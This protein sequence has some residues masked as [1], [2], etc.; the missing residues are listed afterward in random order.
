MLIVVEV[1]GPVTA[2]VESEELCDAAVADE[3]VVAADLIAAGAKVFPHGRI[4]VLGADVVS[5]AWWTCRSLDR[6]IGSFDLV[7][8]LR[9]S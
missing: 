8:I 4:G 2:I 9:S 3:V 5:H 7:A 6:T 1:D